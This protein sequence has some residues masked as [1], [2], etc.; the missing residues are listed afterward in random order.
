MIPN[1]DTKKI[2]QNW[3]IPGFQSGGIASRPGIYKLAE[4]G[5]SEFV[6]PTNPAR[7][8]EAS[9][10]LALAAKTIEQQPGNRAAAAA[11]TTTNDLP[12]PRQPVMIQLVTPDR[13]EFARWIID[14][15]SELQKLQTSRLNLFERR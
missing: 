3:N 2:F 9:K 13:R 4:D 1:N 10:L 14:D 7:R 15:I 6:I 12:Q 11:V 5:F 8:S